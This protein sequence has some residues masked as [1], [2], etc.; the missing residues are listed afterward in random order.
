MSQDYFSFGTEFEGCTPS[1]SQGDITPILVDPNE[2]EYF[3]SNIPTQPAETDIVSTCNVTNNIVRKSDMTSG[4]W[5]IVIEGL[6]FAYMRIFSI[7]AQQPMVVT[8][9]PTAT[10]SVTVTPSTTVVTTS[11][12]VYSTNLPPSTV[13]LPSTTSTFTKTN[14]PAKVT[15]TST[16]T[17]LLTRTSW[18]FSET[19]VSKT[20]TIACPTGL[21]VRDPS[22]TIHP[23]KA[24]LLATDPAS[25]PVK[26]E[27]P[28]ISGVAG[29]GDFNDDK[30]LGK[31]GAG[32]R[33]TQAEED[34]RLNIYRPLY[35]HDTVSNSNHDLYNHL[36][37]YFNRDRY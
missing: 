28:R 20:V 9:T 8:E 16:K 24:S 19:I 5:T 33:F 15:T 29:R 34:K 17:L 3:C 12:Q 6:T 4:D 27:R 31:R 2:D 11:T 10:F 21:P 36:C 14:T 7:I 23:T 32:M 37:S 18:A 26:R 25:T 30:R 22:C 35:H 1:D 13:T